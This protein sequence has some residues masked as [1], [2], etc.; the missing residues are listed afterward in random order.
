MP[1]LCSVT[2]KVVDA[3]NEESQA[4]KGSKIP[5]LGLAYKANVDD[6]RESPSFV[7]MEKLKAKGAD[8]FSITIPLVS[9]SPRLPASMPHFTG[10]EVGRAGRCAM[11]SFCLSTDH[12]EYKNFDFQ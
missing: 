3:L 8:W 6:C 2:T 10:K 7:L 5:V 9:R 12:A 4:L 11:T 1:R